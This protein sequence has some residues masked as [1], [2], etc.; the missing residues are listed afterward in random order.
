MDRRQFA[1]GLV[2]AGLSLNFA[3]AA[4][5]RRQ[6]L[7]TDP[8][9][10]AALVVDAASGKVIYA[11]NAAATRHPAS[12]TK[13][14]TLYLLFEA[15]RA[16]KLT[17][18][19]ELAVSAYAASQPRAHLRLKEGSTITVETA[20]KAMI[21]QSAND[22][23][24]AVAEAVGGNQGVFVVKMNAK[25]RAFGMN[26]TFYNNASGLPD[27]EQITT[28]GDLVILARHLIYDFP[29][30]FPYF[31]TRSMRW[32][33][34]E[35]NTHDNLIGDYP[36]VDGMKT[37]YV[38]ASGYSIL[39]TALRGKTRLIAVVMGGLTPVLRDQAMTQL[40]DAAFAQT[41]AAKPQPERH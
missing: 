14:M 15:L 28:A 25:A 6:R 7:L 37:G 10:D 27:D 36:G 9:L 31:A 34:G 5:A 33:G 39:T 8:D 23:A 13:L 32:S 3:A 20:I 16:K 12:L 17:L 29:Q 18:E 21:I 41:A 40:L 22:V 38:D 30:Y 1:R 35:I 24:V 19:T 2:A 26:D 11:R 4:V